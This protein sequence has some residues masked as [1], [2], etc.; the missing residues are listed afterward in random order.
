MDWEEFLKIT[1]K[2]P[3]I[4]P[5]ALLA[6]V[7]NPALVE[8][9]ISRWKKA[10]KIIQLKKG[11]YLL[12]E[13]YRKIEVYE[14][15]L[16]A[17]LKTPSYISLEKAFEYH[18]LI[19]EAT[20]VFTSVTTKREA[21]FVSKAGIFDYRHIKESLFW[22]YSSVTVNKQTAFIAS[23]EKA[24]LDFFYVKRLKVSLDYLKG[25]RLQNLEKVNVKKLLEYAQRFKK[26]KM[27][28]VAK[29]IKEYRVASKKGEKVL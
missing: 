19:P 3:V 5:E 8:V 16:A 28:K 14:P 6:G 11:M 10:G 7:S 9:Q 22:G 13:P 24:L 4:N 21:R 25:L 29:A 1:S 20:T 18:N 15:Y 2:L 17:V 23:C 12:A 26:P 27:L